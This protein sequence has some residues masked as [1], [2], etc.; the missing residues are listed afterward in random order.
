MAFIMPVCKSVKP[1][2]VGLVLLFI[3]AAVMAQSGEFRVT[4]V[5]TQVDDGL[6]S[7]NARLEYALGPT[8]SEAL[9]NGV[10]LVINQTASL[11][12]VRWWWRNAVLVNQQRRYRLQYHAMSRRYVLTRLSNGESRS[13]R[14][15]DALLARLGHVEGWPLL[16]REQMSAD[17][18][19]RVGFASNLE[20]E[21]LPR[22]LRTVA[23]VDSDWKLSA[24]A[25]KQPVTLP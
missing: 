7:V 3:S 23:L 25:L 22:L 4:E 1:S 9:E 19:Y 10:A 18:R 21:A 12:R 8:V 24:E 5:A 13:F 14:S 11:E 15:L 17:G 2:V 6:L 16:P 20:L